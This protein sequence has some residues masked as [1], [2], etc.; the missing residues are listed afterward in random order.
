MG[1]SLGGGDEERVVEKA[2]A[3]TEMNRDTSVGHVEKQKLLQN[4]DA[5]RNRVYLVVQVER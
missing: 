5:A 3:Q 2:R 4:S 1:D